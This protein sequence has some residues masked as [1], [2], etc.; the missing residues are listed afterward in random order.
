MEELDYIFI[1]VFI[2]LYKSNVEATIEKKKSK[3]CLHG[4]PVNNVYNAI[5]HHKSWQLPLLYIIV[6]QYNNTLHKQNNLLPNCGEPPMHK[7]FR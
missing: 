3:I 5:L 4:Q 6:D 2:F 1:E 7:T